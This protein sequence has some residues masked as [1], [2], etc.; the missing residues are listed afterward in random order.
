MRFFVHK[1]K[2]QKIGKLVDI[3]CFLNQGTWGSRYKPRV[4][5]GNRDTWLSSQWR[6]ISVST[7]HLV[8]VCSLRVMRSLRWLTD[9]ISSLLQRMVACGFNLSTWKAKAGES[10]EFKTSQGYVMRHCFTV[11]SPKKSLFILYIPHNS[12]KHV[13]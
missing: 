3:I 8:K 11:P 5:W 9:F 13:I 6:I 1:V 10:L 2:M 4:F 12:N 7:V